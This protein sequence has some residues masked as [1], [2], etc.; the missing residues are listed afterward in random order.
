MSERGDD[1]LTP[2]RAII[3]G[4]I[5]EGYVRTGVPVGSKTVQEQEGLN[6]ST[7]TIRNEMS[8]L[9]REGYIEQPHTSAGR[10]PLDKGYRTYVDQIMTE[11][12]PRV[13][14]LSWVRAEFRRAACA[15]PEDVYRTASR[16]LS[17]MTSA[18]AM[19]LA[20]PQEHSVLTSLSLSPVSSNIAVLSYKTEPGGE[21]TC[22]LESSEPL[23][24]AQV[25]A[26]GRALAQ[27]FCGRGVAALTMCRPEILEDDLAPYAVPIDLLNEI[28]TALERKW[29]QRVYVDGAAY[30]LDYPEYHRVE[31]LRPVMEALDEDSVVRRLLRPATRQP[32]PAIT[33]GSE[34]ELPRLRHC[35]LVA[36]HYVGPHD[37]LGAVGVIGPTRM[38]YPAVIAAV[39]C[40]AAHMGEIIS[41][42]QDE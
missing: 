40:V 36:R 19:V 2:R 12:P 11:R 41:E 1:R 33:I 17:L 3:L 29:R 23:T 14:E 37:D 32:G 21:S 15:S 8:A 10:I 9:E 39:T 31:L 38:D 16:V 30:A 7:A 4:A 28:K 18:P 5:V 6:I 24:A 27:R 13:E 22:L 42:T 25:Q 26:L 34:Q 35:S 20:P